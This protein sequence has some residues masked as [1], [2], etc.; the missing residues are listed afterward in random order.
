MNYKGYEVVIEFDEDDQVYTD[1]SSMFA[2][3]FRFTANPSRRCARH[4]SRPWTI[5]WLIA[6]N[7]AGILGVAVDPYLRVEQLVEIRPEGT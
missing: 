5:T 1:E 2:T 7:K 6:Q 3:W 4:S